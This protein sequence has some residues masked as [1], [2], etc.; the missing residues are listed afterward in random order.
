MSDALEISL[1]ALFF[2]LHAAYLYWG[3]TSIVRD[4]AA[5]FLSVWTPVTLAGL[6]VVFVAAS[7]AGLLFKQPRTLKIA[8][9]THNIYNTVFS[10]VMLFLYIR[11]VDWRNAPFTSSKPPSNLITAVFWLNY[12]SKFAEFGDTFFFFARGKGDK[13]TTL[14]VVHH[15]EMGPLMWW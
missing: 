3:Y 4:G 10:A 2:S 6:Y 11:D 13:A 8:M 1:T 12:Q 15:A 14:H 5:A 9:A 7:R